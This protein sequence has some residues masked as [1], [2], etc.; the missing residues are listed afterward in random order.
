MG[1]DKK[2]TIIIELGRLKGFSNIRGRHTIRLDN[3][4][5]KRNALAQRLEDAGC[6]VDRVGN[7]WLS[8]GD[9]EAAIEE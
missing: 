1:R 8:V 3:S 7:D 9:F 2:R 5:E 4:P 6:A